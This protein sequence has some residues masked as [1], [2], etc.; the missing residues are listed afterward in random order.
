M[1]RLDTDKNEAGV[2]VSDEEDDINIA[3]ISDVHS[4]LEALN[5]VMEDIYR[6]KIHKIFCLG[7]TV[8]YGAHPSECLAIV[9][10]NAD[11]VLQGNHEDGVINAGNNRELF[12]DLAWL[13]VTYSRKNLSCCDT[14]YIKK[15]PK[16]YID[17]KLGITLAHGTYSEPCIWDYVDDEDAAKSQLE[18]IPTKVCF[19]GHTHRS[20][21][22]GSKNGLYSHY[23]DDFVLADD[24]K[25]LINV[26]SVGQP[27]DGDCRACYAMLTIRGNTMTLNFHRVFYNIQKSADAIRENNLSN[28]L[29]ERLFCGE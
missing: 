22:F 20:F 28:W 25:F 26:G 9:K 3:I 8:G 14:L 10:R 12:N 6:Y 1:R 27:R 17:K 21:I 24:E 23:P 19:I 15:L 18:I 5:A 2:K 29:A 7:D 11:V 4:N 16:R 13:G